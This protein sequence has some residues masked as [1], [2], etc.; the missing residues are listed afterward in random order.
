MGCLTEAKIK[1]L[2]QAGR[3]RDG[4]CLFLNVTTA[5]TRSWVVRVKLRNGPRRD[6]GIGPYPC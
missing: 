3:Y 2:H 5:G 1:T 6:L 4:D